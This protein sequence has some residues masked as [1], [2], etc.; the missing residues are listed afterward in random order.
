MKHL[1]GCRLGSKLCGPGAAVALMEN[2]VT[3]NELRW[4]AHCHKPSTRH[5]CLPPEQ[6]DVYSVRWPE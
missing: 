5:C 4:T 1:F 2:G 6:S 3:D